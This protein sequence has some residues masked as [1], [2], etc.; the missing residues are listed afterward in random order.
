[1]V[2]QKIPPG[3]SKCQPI[4][5][6]SQQYWK[7]PTSRAQK[8]TKPQHFHLEQSDRE[9][10]GACERSLCPASQPAINLGCNDSCDG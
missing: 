6:S 7:N 8:M 4:T 5:K 9:P 10:L 1:M 2:G 3:K